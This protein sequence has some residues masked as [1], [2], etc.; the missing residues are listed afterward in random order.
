[1]LLCTIVSFTFFSIEFQNY[2]IIKHAF[3]GFSYTVIKIIQHNIHVQP[4]ITCLQVTYFRS[5]WL[6]IVIG[7]KKYDTNHKLY[8]VLNYIGLSKIIFKL[9]WINI[10]ITIVNKLRLRL[11]FSIHS[12]VLFLI[13]YCYSE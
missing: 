9:F 3:S 13:S 7:N 10:D 5:F 4:C 11:H 6:I 12:F 1:M 2:Y 8:K